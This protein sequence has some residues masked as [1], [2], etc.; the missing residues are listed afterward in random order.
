MLKT[1]SLCNYCGYRDGCTRN[2][3]TEYGHIMLPQDQKIERCETGIMD[4]NTKSATP[5]ELKEFDDQA[6]LEKKLSEITEI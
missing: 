2:G 6:A 1:D 5:T 4:I 3:V